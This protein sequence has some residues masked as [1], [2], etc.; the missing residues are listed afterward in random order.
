MWELFSRSKF[1]ENIIEYFSSFNL[2]SILSLYFLPKGQESSP[3]RSACFP[4]VQVY[5]SLCVCM[6][7]E[8]YVDLSPTHYTYG[9]E[10]LWK[11]YDIGGNLSP[12]FFIYSF[13]LKK[14]AHVHNCG[15]K[16]TL[17]IFRY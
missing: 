6:C 14:M 4:R 8:V 7:E 9:H 5:I 17:L 12:E 10:T 2:H 1:M 3:L 11:L 16:I 13:S 15:E